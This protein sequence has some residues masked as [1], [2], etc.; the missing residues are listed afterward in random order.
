LNDTIENT[1]RKLQ[2]LKEAE[3]Q[4]QEQFAR[5]DIGADQYR[6]FQRELQDTESYLRNTQNALADLEQEQQQIG[7]ATRELTQLFEATGS[8]LE[9]YED[10][11][12]T[13]LVRAIQQGTASSRDLD[14]AF[15]LVGQSATGSSTDITSLRQSIRQLDQ[16]TASIQDVRRELQRLSEDAEESTGSVKELGGELT[17]LVAGAGAGLGI[18]KIFEEAMNLS[19]L[20]TTIEL[21]M[22][23][24]E[25]SKQSVK[26]AISTVGG[27]IGD[28]EAALEGVRKQ[29]QLNADLTDEQNQKILEGA[30]TIAR[31]YSEIDFTELIQESYE[32]ANSMNMTQEEA[33]G[34][35]KT[36]LDMGF[37]PEQLDIISEYGNQLSMAGYTASEIQGIFA[38]GIETGT[39]N[40]DNLLDGLKEGRIKLAEFGAEVP[41]AVKESLAGT[42]ISAKQVQAWGT[43]MASGGEQGKQAMMDVALALSQVEDETKRNELGATFFGTLWEEQ[44]KKIT[45]TIIGAKDNVGDLAENTRQ[46]NEDTAK[47]DA[48]PQ[49]RLTQAIS[50]LW[51][52]LA[53]VLIMV[54]EFVGQVADWMA[55]NPELTATIM[56]VVAVVGILMGIFIAIAPIVT[57][58]V[59]LM[60]T[61]SLTLGA[62]ASPV[63]IVIGVIAALIAIGVLLWKNWDEI[64]AGWVKNIDKI[65][66]SIEAWASGVKKRFNE[67]IQSAKDMVAKINEAFENWKNG[68]KERFNKGIQD[69]KDLWNGLMNFFRNIDL[70][71]TGK[72]I[73]QGLINGIGSM[74]SKVKEKAGQIANGIGEKIK[75]ILKLGSPS[76][77]LIGMGQDSGEGLAIGLYDKI[78]KVQD[79]S[80][81]LAKAVTNTVDT[82]LGAF[83]TDDVALTNY[84]EA[85]REDGDWLN[86]WLTHMPKKMSDV[87]REMG[88]MVAPNLERKELGAVTEAVKQAKQLTVN[89]NSPKALDIREASREFNK[90][91][92][93]MSLMW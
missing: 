54:A 26:D 43:A 24:P 60:G 65:N 3:A 88:K 57:A 31:A 85:I 14:R 53:P 69:V 48:S 71:Q 8:S 16:G 5:G 78:S 83:T 2:A 6:A 90:T 79:M 42:D 87:A 75:S 41:K 81:R 74:A 59:G 58:V 25:E 70:K 40:I 55:K 13:R 46:L 73:I 12:G 64:S 32:M 10:Q 21:S 67:S 86:D 36:L 11:L 28:N 93:K 27:Y 29:F 4:V 23:I 22:E 91:L 68:V 15:D 49:Q 82:G 45:D 18:G 39:W 84:F 80:K 34:M 77:V 51:T 56:G 72:D 63:L 47:L 7:R 33:L 50:D 66:K 62:I 44:G 38:S 9:D 20:D 37:P 1:E 92:N 61:F 76:K 52:T 19:N 30:G 17:G 35:T 89:L